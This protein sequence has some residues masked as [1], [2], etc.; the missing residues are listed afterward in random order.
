ML[1]SPTIGAF[2]VLVGMSAVESAS[3]ESAVNVADN[4][5]L[6]TSRR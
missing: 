1:R 3:F 2:S 6:G 5:S 4:R